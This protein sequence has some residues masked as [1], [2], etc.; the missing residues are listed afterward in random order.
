LRALRKQLRIEGVKGVPRGAR[1][2]TQSNPYGLTRREAEVLELL[3]DGLRNSA[4]AKRLFVSPK[5]I[6]HHVSS[7]LMKLGVPSRGEA[8]TILRKGL[9]KPATMC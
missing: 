9:A 4:I 7:I 6:D 3:S 1:P 8:V 2:S 5:T